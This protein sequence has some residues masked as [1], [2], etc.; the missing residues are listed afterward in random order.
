MMAAG[1]GEQMVMR[2]VARRKGLKNL[3]S[4]STLFALRRRFSPRFP[5]RKGNTKDGGGRAGG[6]D[7]CW[8]NSG[9]LWVKLVQLEEITWV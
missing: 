2:P 1:L 7:L 3:V 9:G 5:P 6:G 8:V 4:N